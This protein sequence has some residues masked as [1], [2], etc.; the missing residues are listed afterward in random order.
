LIRNGQDR[1]DLTA[2][3]E[4]PGIR[5]NREMSELRKGRKRK[6]GEVKR[7][8]DR[9]EGRIRMEKILLVRFRCFRWLC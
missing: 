2:G 7:R 6:N 3:N 1:E 8:E 5:R 9:S 4:T